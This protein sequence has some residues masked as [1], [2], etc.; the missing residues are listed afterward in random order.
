MQA[1]IQ[2]LWRLLETRDQALQGLMLQLV[3]K[4]AAIQQKEAAI[5][6]KEAAIHELAARHARANGD[7]QLVWQLLET[8][9]H[10]LQAVIPQ[11]L[12]K[13]AFIQRL[14][15]RHRLLPYR[16]ASLTVAAPRY[17]ASLA[18]GILTVAATRYMAPLAQPIKKVFRPR[19]GSLSRHA[20]VP[21]RT[22]PAYT[23]KVAREALPQISIVIPT[24]NQGHFIERTLL[25]VLDQ[26]Y[27]RLEYVVQDGGSLDGTKAV[28][29]QYQDRLSYWDSKPDKGQAH[30]INMGFSRTTGEIMAWLNSDDLLLPGAL[31]CVADYFAQHPEVD[32]VYGNRLMIDEKDLEIG[33]WILPGHDSQV[34][35]WADYV[36]QE[37]LFWRRRIWERVGGQVDESFQFAM[38][39]DLL[40]RFRDA[41]ARF[42]HIPRFMGG[43][44]VHAHQK[45]SAAINE[46]GFKEM[47][48]L[49]ERVLGRVPSTEEIRKAVFPFLVKHVV[50]ELGW[51]IRN[52]FRKDR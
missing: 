36:P 1:D 47:N 40:I 45:T 14:A 21:L 25:S 5:Q 42:A 26:A 12:E 33:H 13:E 39:W 17:L 20:P 44:R 22:V 34:L 2:T 9:D 11:V 48:R 28:L 4:E 24:Y 19:L 3:E 16:V 29:T 50:T 8:R 41:G 37:T 7:L 32:V 31:W 30:A 38:D 6:E 27:P 49:R 35:S 43:F 46:I 10:A 18:Q 15:V 23:C 52:Q 51:N